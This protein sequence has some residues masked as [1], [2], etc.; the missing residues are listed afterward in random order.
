MKTYINKLPKKEP[1]QFNKIYENANPISLRLLEKMLQL[2]P[3]QRVT[4][5]EALEHEYLEK[6]HDMDDEPCCIS[7]FDFSFDSQN[8]S[9]ESLKKQILKEI[10][11]YNSPNQSRSSI[12]G[13][14]YFQSVSMYLMKVT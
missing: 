3:L 5:A 7:P 9:K 2:D 8:V 14:I 10:E 1:V 11:F 4:A 6:Y 13:V 12:S